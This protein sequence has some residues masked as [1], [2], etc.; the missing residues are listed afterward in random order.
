MKLFRS[1]SKPKSK[2][3]DDSDGNRPK[4]VYLT[5]S[6]SGGSSHSSSISVLPSRAATELEEAF[7]LMDKDHDGKLSRS[8]LTHVLVS[9]GIITSR[10]T[11][12]S[13]AEAMMRVLDVDGDGCVSLEEFMA[14]KSEEVDEEED[15][16]EE[17]REVFRVFDVNG[18]GRISA[19]EL[20]RVLSAMEEGKCTVEECR[21]MIR[22]VD[23]DGDGFVGFEDFKIMMIGRRDQSSK[24]LVV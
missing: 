1:K 5:D 9:T 24:M 2:S 16:D 17:L 3:S 22:C 15:E 14:I 10:E 13:E 19:E 4:N 7:K 21:R 8:E 12:V 6:T 18:D 23:G 11:A 20:Y